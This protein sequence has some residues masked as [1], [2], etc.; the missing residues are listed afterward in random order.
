MSV[1]FMIPS[2]QLPLMSQADS[3]HYFRATFA[4]GDR[5]LYYVEIDATRSV[6]I[7]Q[8]ELPAG[9]SVNR[10]LNAFERDDGKRPDERQAKLILASFTP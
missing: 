4:N 7:K 3:Y 8:P 6:M 10:P 9:I 5:L 1:S 2:V